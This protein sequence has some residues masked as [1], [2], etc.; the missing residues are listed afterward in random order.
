MKKVLVCATG[1]VCL[2]AV[3]ALAADK[4]GAS[5]T[6]SV[7]PKTATMN[8]RGK[9]VEISEKAVRIERS[10]KGSAEVM[11][12]ALENPAADIA[13][14]D[15]VKIDYTIKDGKLTASRVAKP[16]AEK[17]YRKNGTKQVKEK[18]A[19]ITK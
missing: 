10:I 16:K 8:A 17:N 18:P 6:Q 11:E 15:F 12:F 3:F 5:A 7:L 9:V 14:N 2:L 4:P 19:P 1:I 13:V